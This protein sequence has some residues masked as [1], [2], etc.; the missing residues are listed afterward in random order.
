MDHLT[1]AIWMAVHVRTCWAEVMASP[2][3][4]FR[5]ECVAADNSHTSHTHE[6]SVWASR[7]VG[8]SICSYLAPCLGT[9]LRIF[10]HGKPK[11][12]TVECHTSTQTCRSYHTHQHKECTLWTEIGASWGLLLQYSGPWVR[13]VSAVGLGWVVACSLSILCSLCF[14]PLRMSFRWSDS[15]QA[16]FLF[17]LAP[18]NK[19]FRYE[20][21]L[22]DR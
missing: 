17:V 20:S 18:L 4:L 13:V 5:P 7:Q 16:S 11:T 10:E 8:A 1:N 14:C 6:A 22:S 2:S 3:D 19:A 15:S 12:R 21:M 9:S